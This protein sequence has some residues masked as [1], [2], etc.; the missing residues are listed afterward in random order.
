MY[1]HGF[2]FYVKIVF[3]I[4]L[5]DNERYGYF[6]KTVRFACVCKNA[7]TVLSQSGAGFSV[8]GGCKAYAHEAGCHPSGVETTFE[9]RTYPQSNANCG[10]GADRAE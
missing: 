7:E 4:T 5:Q 8:A 2:L 10:R 3:S 1:K 9:Y 6:G